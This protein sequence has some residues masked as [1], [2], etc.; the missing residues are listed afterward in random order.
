M[1]NH[2]TSVIAALLFAATLAI[3][4]CGSDSTGSNSGLFGPGTGTG[5]TTGT[6]TLPTGQPVLVRL[7]T[8]NLVGDDPPVY[9]KLWV[10]V[11]TDTVG[12][13]LPAQR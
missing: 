9:R 1:K 6:G 8:D 7:G 5:T 10:A 4:G 2:E 3:A 12:T 13:R 11:V